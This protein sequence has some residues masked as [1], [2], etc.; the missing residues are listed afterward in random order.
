MFALFEYGP[1]SS[2][3]VIAV[4]YVLAENVVF[5]SLAG[6]FEDCI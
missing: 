3:A 5:L 1:A 4:V 6:K 2:L